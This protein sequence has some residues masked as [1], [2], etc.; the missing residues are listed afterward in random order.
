MPSASRLAKASDSAWPQSM[1]PV[2]ERLGSPFEHADELR[3]D[4]EALG[5]ADELCRSSRRRSAGTAVSTVA[6]AETGVSSPCPAAGAT[7]DVLSV[8]CAA[9][10]RPCISS[11]SRSA[12][13]A[14]TSP[15]SASR[16]AYSVAHRR[17]AGDLL[18]HQRL[19]ERRLVTLV[20]P[21]PPVADEVDDDVGPK[22]CRNAFARRIAEIAASGSSAFTWMIGLSK[23][24]A[25]SLEY[26]V[27][28]PSAGSVVNPTW[29]FAIRCSVP[30]VV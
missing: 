20:V 16:C 7:R 8:S 9:R 24:F 23:P 13:S 27:E 6:S 10:I 25:R 2:V 21:V 29:L 5:N 1:P 3:I 4:G 26:L 11:T 17:M 28:R 12:S 19:R 22:R 14:E 15:D 30:P 18:G